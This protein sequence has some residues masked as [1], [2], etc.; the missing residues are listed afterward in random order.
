MVHFDGPA[1]TGEFDKD[2]QGFADAF[3]ELLLPTK[4]TRK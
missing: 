3:M 4:V 1:I 2:A